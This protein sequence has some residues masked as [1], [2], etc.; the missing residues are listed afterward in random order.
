M[1]FRAG[2]GGQGKRYPHAET[3]VVV[4]GA[5]GEVEMWR[6]GKGGELIGHAG[7]LALLSQEREESPKERVEEFYR[8]QSDA[9]PG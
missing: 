9:T 3:E 7:A 1:V 8:L 4:S 2:K 5:E 6:C